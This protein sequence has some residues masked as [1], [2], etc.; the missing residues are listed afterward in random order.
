LDQRPTEVDGALVLL[1]LIV[2]AV[3]SHTGV[4]EVAATAG[5]V[6]AASGEAVASVDHRLERL[7]EDSGLKLY[8]PPHQLSIRVSNEEIQVDRV[9]FLGV[10]ACAV[11]GP[12]IEFVHRAGLLEVGRGCNGSGHTKHVEKGDVLHDE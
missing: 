5:V 10:A 9:V 3:A 12:V 6:S 8:L 11:K 4:V 7:H 2:D 1:A